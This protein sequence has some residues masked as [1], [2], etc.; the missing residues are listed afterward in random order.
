MEKGKRHVDLVRSAS[1]EVVVHHGAPSTEETNLYRRNLLK[2]IAVGGGAFLVGKLSGPVSDYFTGGKVI[3]MQD[4]KDF[5]FVETSKELKMLDH[6]GGE[7]LIVDK[8]AIG[9]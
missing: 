7:I 4:F 2:L 5:R 1:G 6:D 8:D 9:G 3:S